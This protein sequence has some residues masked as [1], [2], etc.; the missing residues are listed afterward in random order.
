MVK[1]LLE[2]GADI[3]Y[4]EDYIPLMAA[5][6]VGQIHIVEYLIEQGAD[7]NLADKTHWRSPL[8]VAAGHGKQYVVEYLVE[9]GADV[10]QKNKYGD[11]PH[12]CAL[13][14]TYTDIARYLESKG[15]YK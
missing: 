12:A 4:N 2:H 1:Y 10:N 3:N 14:N 7:V 13:H 5:S 15:A 11:Y 6:A 9:H 8:C